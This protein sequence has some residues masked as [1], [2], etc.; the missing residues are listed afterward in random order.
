MNIKKMTVFAVAVVA[1]VLC[2]A[3]EAEKSA[4]VPSKGLAIDKANGNFHVLEFTRRP[5]GDTDIEIDILYAGICHSDIHSAMGHWGKRKYPFVPGHEIL[6][7]VR[8]VGPKVKR[9]K[10]GD[11]AGIGCIIASCDKCENCK[12]G[13]ENL[14]EKGFIG[15]YAEIDRYHGN[16]FTQGGYSKNYVIDERWAIKVPPH[17]KMECVAPLMCAGVTTYSPLKFMGVTA[18]DKVGVA[19]FGGLGHMAVKFAVSMGAE[20]TVFDITEDKREDA[21]RMGAKRYVNVKNPD[22][23]KGIRGSL[24]K[25]LNTI[26]YNHDVKFYIDA[27]KKNGELCYVG[28]P[29]V[30]QRP[31]LKTTLLTFNSHKRLSGSLIG[32]IPETQDAVDYAVRCGIYPE[33]KIIKADGASVD[34][35]Y[36][37]TQA[38][39]VK[40]RHVIDMSTLK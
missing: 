15:P 40:F 22:D 17:A 35:A 26:P 28:V 3:V 39:K 19:G 8:K 13:D 18:G 33:V 38:G 24:D 30:K 29:D 16:E 10:V 36:I 31:T 4:G 9:F 1:A 11:Y 12:N 23:L 21:F 37:D 2:G 34:Q 27:L 32:G 20:V 6:G 25:I 5:V 14:C 7:R